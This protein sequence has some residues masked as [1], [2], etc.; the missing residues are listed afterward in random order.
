[1]FCNINFISAYLILVS[2]NSVCLKTVSWQFFSGLAMARIEKNGNSFSLKLSEAEAKSLNV[3]EGK[4]YSVAKVRD[5]LF[6]FEESAGAVES[7]QQK[8]PEIA[9]IKPSEAPEKISPFA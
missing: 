5:G 6:V 4:S 1:M 3:L 2:K 9:A 8:S 7:P